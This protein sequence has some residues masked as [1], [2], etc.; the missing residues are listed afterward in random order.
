MDPIGERVERGLRQLRK[1]DQHTLLGDRLALEVANE[2]AR[3]AGRSLEAV[4][5][6]KRLLPFCEAN[7]AEGTRAPSSAARRSVLANGKSERRQAH[8][9]VLAQGKVTTPAV[10]EIE[11]A[12]P[13]AVSAALLIHAPPVTSK[14]VRTRPAQPAATLPASRFSG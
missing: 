2:G 1:P 6:K 3:D 12:V 8:R 5:A 9:L 14:P 13:V 11:A 7:P 10:L 4:G